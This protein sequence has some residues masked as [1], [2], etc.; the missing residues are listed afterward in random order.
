MSPSD[1][2]YRLRGREKLFVDMGPLA[3]MFIGYFFGKRIAPLLDHL[4]G[5]DFFAQEGNALFVAVALFLPAFMVAFIYSV[6]KERRVAP[7]LMVTAIVA[8]FLSTLTL[9]LR[10]K[11]FTYIKPTITYMLFAILLGGG[12]LAGRNF[13]KTL[14]DGA[15]EMPDHAWRT[16]TWRFVGFFVLCALLNELLWRTLTADCVAGSQC[17]GE[18]IWF[19]I[20]LFGFTTLYFVFLLSQGPFLAKYIESEEE[21]PPPTAPISA[22]KSDKQDHADMKTKNNAKTFDAAED[23]HE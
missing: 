8:I 2:S 7:M 12:Q 10:D 16:L 22:P 11:G 3:I 23:R 9:V 20:K 21:N 1:N 14:F 13:M 19:N 18:Q 17:S 4:F 6:V 15:I 5:T